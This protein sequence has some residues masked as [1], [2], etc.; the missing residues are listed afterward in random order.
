VIIEEKSG[1]VATI[2]LVVVQIPL[3]GSFLWKERI[4]RFLVGRYF[5]LKVPFSSVSV[6][7]FYFY[8]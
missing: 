8:F 2:V 1:A 4:C 5:L 7:K 6:I 3:G